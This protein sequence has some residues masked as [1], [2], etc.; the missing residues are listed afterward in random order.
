MRMARGRA[1]GGGGATGIAG[2]V[3]TLITEQ[4]GA[5]GGGIEGEFYNPLI[6]ANL[7]LMVGR[8]AL[9]EWRSAV[10]LCFACFIFL[11]YERGL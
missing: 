3:V 6:C 2:L 8:G 11:I 9:D 1:E 10:F 5:E 4:E 7:A